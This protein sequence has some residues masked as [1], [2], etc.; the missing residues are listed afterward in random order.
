M[1]FVLLLKINF[2]QSYG[3]E[4]ETHKVVTQDG[5]ILTVHRVLAKHVL[6]S[7]FPPVLLQHGMFQTSGTFVGS[8]NSSLAFYL[9]DNG[10]DVWLGNARGNRYSLEHEKMTSDDPKFWDHSFHEIGYYDFPAMIDYILA[11]TNFKQ[12]SLIG[13]SEGGGA[14]AIL[15][16]TRPEYNQKV[17]QAHLMAPGVFMKHFPNEGAKSL[18]LKPVLDF[19]KT[20]NTYD[21]A[22][23]NLFLRSAIN[24]IH[25]NYKS[26]IIC[27]NPIF[28]P[29][30]IIM[31]DFLCA[32]KLTNNHIIDW[33]FIFKT[34]SNI[35][36]TDTLS[37]KKLVHFAQ[38]IES[39]KF[40]Q[41]DYGSN[42]M[43]FYKSLQPPNYNL[44]QF[45]DPAFIYSGG[46]DGLVGPADLIHLKNVLPNVKQFKFLPNYSHCDFVFGYRTREDIYDNILRALKK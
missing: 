7:K 45:K 44:K 3:Y 38:L 15:L 36:I 33:P 18:L 27:S 14:I 29:L 2:V 20:Q 6:K 41:F 19:F 24:L 43:K 8:G 26:G 9:A 12:I 25:Q 40:R 17:N 21:H 46:R 22:F 35:V 37:M 13:F 11:L 34:H 39:G 5:Y 42:N 1:I 30:C 31:A 4:C 32:S 16:S 23:N 28:E 10:F